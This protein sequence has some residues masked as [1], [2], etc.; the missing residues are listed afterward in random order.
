MYGLDEFI[1]LDAFL[2]EMQIGDLRDCNIG[3][4]DNAPIL[5][6]YSGFRHWD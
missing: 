3:Y 4:L 1:R 6:D 5:F 2:N